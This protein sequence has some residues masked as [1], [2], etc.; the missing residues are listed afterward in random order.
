VSENKDA[1]VEKI[2]KL[3]RMKRGGTPGEIENALAAAAELARKHSIDL[4]SIN[5]DE[6]SAKERLT[7]LQELL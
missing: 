6:E 3:L 7:H 5:P 1:I 2:K 4:G